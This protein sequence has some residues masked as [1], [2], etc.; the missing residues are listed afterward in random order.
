MA[1]AGSMCAPPISAKIEPPHT[2]VQG[3]TNP[4][5]PQM[6]R[7]VEIDSVDSV[8]CGGWV[9]A[10]HRKITFTHPTSHPPTN[11]K[12]VGD[13]SNASFVLQL[14]DW[15]GYFYWMANRS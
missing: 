2:P 11:D 1:T 5:R 4:A 12:A 8:Q 15:Q 3:P 6:R 14:A 7:C 10:R 13:L 9:Q